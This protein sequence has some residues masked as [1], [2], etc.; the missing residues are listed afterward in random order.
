MSPLDQSTSEWTGMVTLTPGEL[1][2]APEA[3]DITDL[4]PIFKP[5]RR[6]IETIPTGEVE[7][8]SR[9]SF[10]TFVLPLTKDAIDFPKQFTSEEPNVRLYP[11]YVIDDFFAYANTH[12]QD[13]PQ[14]ELGYGALSIYLD[15]EL[16]ELRMRTYD[17]GR[18]FTVANIQ[19]L[20]THENLDSFF[21]HL[22]RIQD[23][24]AELLN[25]FYLDSEKPQTQTLIFQDV[26]PG[27]HIRRFNNI[28]FA[29]RTLYQ[30]FGSHVSIELN[31]PS[32][33]SDEEATLE[34]V[35]RS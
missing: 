15:Q 22:Q 8:Q 18:D 26:F 10:I 16:P 12:R 30:D 21:A 11:G 25:A 3:L 19:S 27:V 34:L 6:L 24:I 28:L 32:N 9:E 20:V 17:P 2:I 29:A 7:D 31:E 5:V 4:G 1:T 14:F 23:R 33:L 35:R 13:K